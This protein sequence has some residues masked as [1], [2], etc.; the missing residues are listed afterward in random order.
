M[1]VKLEHMMGS[2]SP[3]RGGWL[4]KLVAG[5]VLV[6]A[7]VAGVALS[8]FF[9]GFFLVLAAVMGL[10]VWWQQWR[11]RRRMRRHAGQTRTQTHRKVIQGEYEVVD[12]A[13]QDPHRQRQDSR[14]R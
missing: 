9:F 6:A 8:A 13:G 7:I 14:R 12:D 11:L 3:L 1:S 2:F 4:S 10:W 5:L